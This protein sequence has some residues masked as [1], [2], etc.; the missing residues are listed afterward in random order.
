MLGLAFVFFGD[1]GDGGADQQ[2]VAEA[3]GAWCAR[4][5][6]DF[7]LL[8]GDN[9]YPA[10]VEGAEDPLWE[11]VF[12]RPYGDLGLPF[13]VLLGNHDHLGVVQGQLDYRSPAPSSWELPAQFWRFSTD[14]ADFFLVDSTRFGP[15]QAAWLD[16]GLRRSTAPWKIVA[17]HHPLPWHGRHG[18][19]PALDRSL[20]PLLRGRASFY[21]AGHEHNLQVDVQ[22]PPMVVMGGGG[23]ALTPVHGGP[24][25]GWSAMAHGFGWMSLDAEQAELVVVGREGDV[26][27]RRRWP[28]PWRRGRSLVEGHPS[29]GP[30]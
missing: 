21:L 11:Q 8:L 7:V 30:R 9:A 29:K 25:T 1:A 2:A 17:G 18:G 24:W 13:K 22:D 14:I 15:F 20:W 6:C 28:A 12:V 23:A 16:A 3:V 4:H 27:Y 19:T 10:G 26:L 5:R